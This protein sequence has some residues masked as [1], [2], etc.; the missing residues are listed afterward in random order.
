MAG[1]SP[2]N[3]TLVCIDASEHSKRALECKYMLDSILSI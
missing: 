2:K 1:E 3:L